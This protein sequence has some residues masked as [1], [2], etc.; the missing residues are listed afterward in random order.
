MAP[1]ITMMMATAEAKTGRSVKKPIMARRL[2]TGPKVDVQNRPA[3]FRRRVGQI[4]QRA[5]VERRGAIAPQGAGDRRRRPE[6][7]A[8]SK[9]RSIIRR[10]AGRWAVRA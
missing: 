10:C 8:W 6:G 2:R 7:S 4:P 9:D 1:A 5:E 3:A